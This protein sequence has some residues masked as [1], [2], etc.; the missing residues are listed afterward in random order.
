MFNTNNLMKF[1]ASAIAALL[2]LLFANWAA[3]SMYKV[4]DDAGHGE[5]GDEEHETP[6]GYVIAA[7]DAEDHGDEPEDVVEVS[8]EEVY[9]AADA[10]AG[11]KEF[12]A[13]KACHKLEDGANSTGPYL[14]GL[15]DRPMAAVA[16]FGYSDALTALQGGSWTPDEI[17]KYI[18]NPKDYAPGNKMTYKGMKDIEDRANLIAY[19]ATIGG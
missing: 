14:W 2:I 17:Q 18:E 6:R 4:A 3:S 15:V 5:H 8:F 16:D 1:G 9:A 12:K 10:A 11:E 19:L 13:C 7:M